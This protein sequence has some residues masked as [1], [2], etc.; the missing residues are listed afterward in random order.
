MLFI[1]LH[2]YGSDRSSPSYMLSTQDHYY[3]IVQYKH[4]HL[5]C[6]QIPPRGYFLAVLRIIV[7]RLHH[8]T[9]F[10]L[11]ATEVFSRSL[12]YSFDTD[13]WRRWW[14]SGASL[15]GFPCPLLLAPAGRS[16]PQ[17]VRHKAGDFQVA[18]SLWKSF[19]FQP[20]IDYSTFFCPQAKASEGRCEWYTIQKIKHQ[21]VA[22]GHQGQHG[23][24]RP[25]EVEIQLVFEWFI[26]TR[27]A[28]NTE[29]SA[30]LQPEDSL[31][32]PIKAFRFDSELA[33]KLSQLVV[34]WFKRFVPSFPGPDCPMTVDAERL[35]GATVQ[36][37]IGQLHPFIH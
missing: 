4:V 12:L 11:P 17:R 24:G 9:V 14:R 23:Q 29:N 10:Y 26:L 34:F 20:W 13:K 18:K 16:L 36:V 21:D 28:L 35:L 8:G 5:V 1:G 19:T 7:P 15:L 37:S 2:S 6:K 27:W 30:H 32:V 33:L 25:P 3:S 31:C 22:G